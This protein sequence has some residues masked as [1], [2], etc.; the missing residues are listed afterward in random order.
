[1]IVFPMGA[2]LSRYQIV[3]YVLQ[4]RWPD[5]THSTLGQH[6]LY[7]RLQRYDFFFCRDRV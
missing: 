7:S 1:M 6:R 3:Q 2:V 5:I 4:S